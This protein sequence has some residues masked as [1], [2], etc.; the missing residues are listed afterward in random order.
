VF[1]H[2]AARIRGAAFRDALDNGGLAGT[3]RRVGGNRCKKFL[4]CKAWI[5]AAG[6]RAVGRRLSAA[7]SGGCYRALRRI[8]EAILVHAHL[9]LADDAEL[10][11]G[12]EVIARNR[13]HDLGI[14]RSRPRG[15]FGHTGFNQRLIARLQR[16][17]LL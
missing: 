4:A 15:R 2:E 17:L 5:N 8:D 3:E 7:W 11:L 10:R 16:L 1:Q 12:V 13:F 14:E 9:V 6:S